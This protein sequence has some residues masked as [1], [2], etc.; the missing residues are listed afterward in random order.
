MA[1]RIVETDFGTKEATK[2]TITQIQLKKTRQM[3]WLAW[4]YWWKV[5]QYALQE[6]PVG[7]P[8]TTGRPNY[9]GG[10]L[11]MSIRITRGSP[12]SAVFRSGP[13]GVSRQTYGDSSWIY[14]IQAG[15]G[16]VINPNY[17][18]EVDYAAAVHDGHM[19]RGGRWIPPNRFL[20]RAIARAEGDYMK[21]A[22]D[23]LSWFE[24]E[25]SK[26]ALNNVPPRGFYLP[27]KFNI[28]G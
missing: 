17:G 6:C 19:G 20:D 25:W 21:M 28:G 24:G 15:G 23:M 18:R 26:G 27:T 10:S 3:Q 11:R 8:A 16:G 14:S 2:K 13:Y 7:T 4:R 1:A 9:I 12:T 22:N 5:Y